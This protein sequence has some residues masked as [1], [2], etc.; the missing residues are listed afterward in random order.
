MIDPDSKQPLYHQVYEALRG[1]ILRGEWL[2]GSLLPSEN[3]L[4]ERYDLSRG[5]I[6][7]A[8][9][10]LVR[11]GLVYRRQGRG[12]YVAHPTFQQAAGKMITFSEDMRRRGLTP[13]TEVLLSGIVAA[14][15]DIAQK[16]GVKGGEPLARIVR[17]RLADAEPMSIEDSYLVSRLCPGVLL[18]D[19]SR[20]SLRETLMRRYGLEQVRGE[21]I[22]RAVPAFGEASQRLKIKPGK[23]ALLYLERVT[24]TQLDVPLE[25]L[26]V[27]HRGDRYAIHND[28]SGWQ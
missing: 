10:V 5:T 3:E 4:V 1:C 15:G 9:G 16:L 12:T 23:A 20:A 13:S 19:Y 18:N 6:R 22:I 27:Y 24:Y 14:Q 2:P 8:L 28:L 11:D 17:L 21:Q 7:Q 25:F 26:K